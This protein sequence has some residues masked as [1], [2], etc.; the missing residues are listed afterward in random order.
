MNRNFPVFRR[1]KRCFKAFDMTLCCLASERRPRGRT[2][3]ARQM[4]KKRGGWRRSSAIRATSWGTS[5]GGARIRRGRGL[6]KRGNSGLRKSVLSE[7]LIDWKGIGR[8]FLT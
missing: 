4:R 6:G 3:R 5:P 2:E 7:N 1:L 8:E